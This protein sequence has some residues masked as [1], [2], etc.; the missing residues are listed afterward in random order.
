MSTVGPKAVRP[1][2]PEGYGISDDPE[3]LLD[4]GWAE[5]RLF[6][7]RNYW[8]CTTRSDGSPHAAPVWG[9]WNEGGVVFGTAPESR[10]ARNLERDS[11]VLVHLESG[12]DVVIVEGRADPAELDERIAEAYA[13]KYD[14]RPDPTGGSEGWYRVVPRVAYAWLERDYPGTATRFEF[15]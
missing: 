9:L 2:F 12:D 14:F 4:W 1:R 10:K 7:A 13:E 8:I 11:R 3:G 5:E 15:G 6:T